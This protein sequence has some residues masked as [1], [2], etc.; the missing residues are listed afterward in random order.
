MNSSINIAVKLLRFEQPAGTEFNR[1]TEEFEQYLRE[2]IL[3]IAAPV[4]ETNAELYETFCRN[5]S[6]MGIGKNPAPSL[7]SRIIDFPFWSR[8]Q[9][10]QCYNYAADAERAHADG[11]FDREKYNSLWTADGS[12][13][14][15][16]DAQQQYT[17]Y[18]APATNNDMLALDFFSPW[19]N[20]ITN[21]AL[22][23]ESEDE[24][25]GYD[26][27][28][29]EKVAGIIDHA[30]ESLPYASAHAHELVTRFAKTVLL[31]KQIRKNGLQFSS[32]SFYPDIGQILLIN[33]EHAKT[34]QI[35]DALVHESVHA[36]LY[37]IDTVKKWM[38]ANSLIREKGA[39]I[40]S[41]W[42]GKILTL[43]NYAQAL[44]VWYGLY[45]FWLKAAAA[46]IYSEAF[47]CKRLETIR[48]GFAQV[49]MGLLQQQCDGRL[50][51]EFVKA[52]DAMQT[53]I[54]AAKKTY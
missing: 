50:D 7:I 19:C 32:A 39:C 3:N 17:T 38:P 28:E 9:V 35:A 8:E 23:D 16:P 27:E 26:F 14:I 4:K 18:E 15:G 43:G 10:L 51:A 22:E 25:S 48:H 42:T 6:G 49:N 2:R 53:I 45:H 40:P 33:S 30:V 54:G 1:L 47:A 37:T 36:F 21:K 13:Y 46:G 34:E 29:C 24:I 31:K 52:A 12:F 5:F 11:T 20:A 44:F 41:P